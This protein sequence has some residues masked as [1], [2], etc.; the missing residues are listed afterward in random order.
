LRTTPTAI[1]E[2]RENLGQI[3]SQ[4][5]ELGLRVN[6]DRALSATFGYQYAHAVVTAFSA[7]PALV[8]NWIPD[9]PRESA[10]A[11]LR[12]ASRRFGTAIFA[13]RESGRAF[14]DSSNTFVLHSFFA[15]D[16]YGERS[17]AHRWTLFLAGQNL[18]DRKIDVARTPILTLGTPFTMQGGVRFRWGASELK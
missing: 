3:Q 16:A 13:L 14:D 6:Q 9:V 10:T 1:T 5:V 4:G 17:F 12:A 8:G 2:M 11:Q 18:L 7:Q 15:M